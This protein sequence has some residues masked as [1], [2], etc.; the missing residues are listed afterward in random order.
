M[1]LEGKNRDSAVEQVK[2][3]KFKGAFSKT[4]TGALYLNQLS[5]NTTLY[6]ICK[7]PYMTLPI[8]M[9]VQK[10]F[11]LLDEIN[12]KILLFQAAGLIEHRHSKTVDSNFLNIKE[13]IVLKKLNM[14][15]LY[16]SF[17]I[18]FC[19]C[20]IGGLIFI[21]EIV[22]MRKNHRLTLVFFLQHHCLQNISFRRLL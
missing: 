20:A 4:L 9:Y 18:W 10:N 15:H 5:F 12:E 6:K 3:P 14:H 8:V 11:Y 1:S 19:G 21:T 16:G 2:D 13:E 7:E 17:Q 22:M